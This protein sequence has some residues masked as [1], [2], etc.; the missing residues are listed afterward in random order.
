MLQA[1]V[2]RLAGISACGL[3]IEGATKNIGHTLKGAGKQ[4]GGRF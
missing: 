4:F 1:L 3:E 2:V